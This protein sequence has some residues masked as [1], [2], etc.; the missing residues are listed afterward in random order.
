MSTSTNPEPHDNLR[1]SV[2]DEEPTDEQ[3]G[4]SLRPPKKRRPEMEMP[5]RLEVP[6]PRPSSQDP[7]VPRLKAGPSLMKGVRPL[8]LQ[9]P[10]AVK[11]KRLQAVAV[12]QAMPPPPLVTPTGGDVPNGLL[13]KMKWP[14]DPPTTL[15]K[16]KPKYLKDWM[17]MNAGGTVLLRPPSPP[18]KFG[19]R[20]D[21]SLGP[22]RE[23]DNLKEA[24]DK[25]RGERAS[26]ERLKNPLKR[27]TLARKN[28]FEPSAAVLAGLKRKGGGGQPVGSTTA[29][30]GGG[31]EKGGGARAPPP[32]PAFPLTT[33][34]LKTARARP[35]RVRKT[36][37][38]V[39][40]SAVTHPPL[41]PL[42]SGLGGTTTAQG[43]TALAKWSDKEYDFM[44][45]LSPQE[46]DDD[47]VS[48][49]GS[50]HEMEDDFDV[51][52]PERSE[53]E[54]QPPP[55]KK[56]RKAGGGKR[57]GARAEQ[58]HAQGDTDP[59]E[60]LRNFA[61]AEKRERLASQRRERVLTVSV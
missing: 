24:L 19:R 39:A 59:M 51:S 40:A 10:P 17:M 20:P 28:R 35:P 25:E 52:A 7:P 33:V 61:D 23:H 49:T 32:P 60:A 37:S 21:T 15:P 53:Y 38:V 11:S 43:M 8:P 27:D 14:A 16:G 34:P 2:S 3:S 26:N 44:A 42:F 36:A 30:G 46:E 29:P 45:D 31:E 48:D 47:F 13:K 5:D 18:V 1:M 54:W 6:D 55:E 56:A 12:L 50:V 9:A 58:R 41:P 57:G 4:V 22:S